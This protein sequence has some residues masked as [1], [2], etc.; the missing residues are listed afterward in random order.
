MCGH[1][2][3]LLGGVKPSQYKNI[4]TSK[5]TM[6]NY[7][8]WATTKFDAYKSGFGFKKCPQFSCTFPQLS[9]DF[10]NFIASFFCQS[11]A[12]KWLSRVYSSLIHFNLFKLHVNYVSALL[13]CFF[14][15][16]S[17]TFLLFVIYTF[18]AHFS[19]ISALLSLSFVSLLLQ[20]VCMKVH[21]L[22]IQTQGFFP[23]SDL[24]HEQCKGNWFRKGLLFFPYV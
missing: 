11:L 21:F 2:K 7:N 12:H 4:H 8:P 1:N 6:K 13:Q 5:L 18:S 14:D 9:L 23:W 24:D 3:V 20:I 16:F 17:A 10:H 15:L 22:S 19:P